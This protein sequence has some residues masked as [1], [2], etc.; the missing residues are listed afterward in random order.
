[1]ERINIGYIGEKKENRLLYPIEGLIKHF[2]SLGSSGSGKTVLTKIIIE[3]AALK[4][5]PSIIIDPQGDLASLAQIN[6]ETQLKK[7]NLLLNNAIKLSKVPVKIFTPASSKGIPLSVNPLKIIEG[8]EKVQIADQI[9]TAITKLIGFNTRSEKGSA[10]KGILYTLLMHRNFEDFKEL[11]E[12]M[13]NLP[14]T[15]KNKI[16]S[17]IINDNHL[18]SIIRK[19][20][21]LTMGKNQMLFDQGTKLNIGEMLRKPSINIIYLNSLSS[22][23]EKEFFISILVKDL[24]E[25]M[26]KNPSPRLQALFVMDE[27][28]PF[29]PAGA[30]KPITKDILKLLYK[31]ARKYSLGCLVA[32]QNPGDIDYMA[33]AQFGTWSVGRL[34]TKQ[35]KNKVQEALRSVSSEDITSTLPKLRPGE[36]MLFSPDNYKDIVQFKTRWLY[37]NHR[38]ITEDE[39]MKLVKIKYRTPKGNVLEG[40]FLKTIKGFKVV[41]ISD[42]Y[43][44]PSNEILD[45]KENLEDVSGNQP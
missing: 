16:S 15:I 40:Y 32:T 45:I 3:E 19:L 21:L 43:L 44:D 20:T 29:L 41:H 37:T 22:Q 25:W 2:I 34:T 1:M 5:I 6:N 28:S 11:T 31:Q 24:Y 26:L 35:D 30:K 36:F 13:N 39:I 27:I 4:G 33:F 42:V 8:D 38:T 17:L 9:A 14:D 12:Y 23:E 18:D 7:H 10:T